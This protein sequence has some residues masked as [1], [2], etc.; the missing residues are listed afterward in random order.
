MR[1]AWVKGARR[2]TR[3]KLNHKTKQDIWGG[4]GDLSRKR[5]AK[6]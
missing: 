3:R 1:Q 4:M 2:G 5:Y 6:I